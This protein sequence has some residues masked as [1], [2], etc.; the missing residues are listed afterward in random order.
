MYPE[1]KEA[2]IERFVESYA[3]NIAAADDAAVTAHFAE[4]F[5]AG[6]PGG[7]MAVR[8]VDFAKALPRRRQLFADLGLRASSLVAAEQRALTDRFWLVTTRWQ[9]KFAGGE[10]RIAEEIAS[11]TVLIVDTGAESF[12]IVMFLHSED[13]AAL[14]SKGSEQLR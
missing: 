11:E 10:A 6:G 5:M 14:R 3:A 4:V 2:A 12:Q 7:V 1:S 13:V 9:M 8:A